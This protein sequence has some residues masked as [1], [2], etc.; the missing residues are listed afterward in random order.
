MYCNVCKK[1]IDRSEWYIHIDS[2]EHRIKLFKKLAKDYS[3]G[4]EYKPLDKNDDS[5]IIEQ[6]SKFNKKFNTW[7]IDY[8]IQTSP[9]VN[10]NKVNDL[11]INQ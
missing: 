5:R 3:A 9:N 6:N 1:D 7:M 8:K 4:E 11:L 2:E 10:I